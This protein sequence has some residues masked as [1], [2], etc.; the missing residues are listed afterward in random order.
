KARV[1]RFL[2]FRIPGLGT[3]D[4][5]PR[6]I[7]TG[8]PFESPITR[9]GKCDYAVIDGGGQEPQ[10]DTVKLDVIDAHPVAA[11]PAAVVVVD[12]SKADDVI[13]AEAR[14]RI[15]ARQRERRSDEGPEQLRRTDNDLSLDEHAIEIDCDAVAR[16][17]WERRCTTIIRIQWI[18]ATASQ[19]I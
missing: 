17:H 8:R 1:I 2:G 12:T 13:G 7:N 9:P 6:A 4:R 18:R 16:I 3:C 11:V 10:I 5:G 14:L 15:H 19:S